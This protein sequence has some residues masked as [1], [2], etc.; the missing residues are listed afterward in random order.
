MGWL[1]VQL[2]VL[3]APDPSGSG[4]SG[5]PFDTTS[6]PA[7]TSTEIVEVALAWGVAWWG[8]PVLAGLG[9]LMS[10]APQGVGIQPWSDR[11]VSCRVAGTPPYSPTTVNGPSTGVTGVTTS[12]SW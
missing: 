2:Q 8:S 4:R 6:S 11:P 9:W 5:S 3:R 10:V 7:G 1:S 12:L